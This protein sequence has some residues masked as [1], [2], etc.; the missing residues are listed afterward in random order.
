MISEA[1]VQSARLRMPRYERPIQPKVLTEKL[2]EYTLDTA[3]HQGQLAHERLEI[4]AQLHALE[5]E[6][7]DLEGWQG[8]VRGKTDKAVLVAKRQVNPDLYGRVR[9]ARW[10]VARLTDEIE[11]LERD[12]IKASRAYSILSAS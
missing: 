7:E 12:S 5:Q 3:F 6:W 4:Y 10:L 11:R 2:L 9:A 1:L 8:L